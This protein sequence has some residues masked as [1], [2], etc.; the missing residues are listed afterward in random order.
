MKTLAI[1]TG[2]LL[3]STL[4]CGLWLASAPE[5]EIEDSSVT[6]HMTLGIITVGCALLTMFLFFRQPRT[7]RAA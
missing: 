7:E 2:L 1:I 3:L 6:F 5:S 4:I